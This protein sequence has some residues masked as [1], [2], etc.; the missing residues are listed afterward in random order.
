MHVR[1]G[2]ADTYDGLEITA[3]VGVKRTPHIRP[4]TA[5]ILNSSV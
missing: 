2:G 1:E 3:V 5:L 4:T